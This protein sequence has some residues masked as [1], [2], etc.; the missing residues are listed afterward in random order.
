MDNAIALIEKTIE[1]HKTYLDRLKT[2]NDVANDV[3]ALRSLDKAQEAFVPG[4]LDA[5]AGLARLAELLDFIEHGL[6]A[7]FNREERALL[8]IFEK[9]GNKEM[10]DGFNS[11]LL[12]HGD[13]RNRI[14]QTRELVQK[15]TGGGLSGSQW[16]AT[17]NDLR[18]HISHTE[19]LLEAHADVEQELF[20]SLRNRLEFGK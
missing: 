19:K 1:E 5:K 10:M 20:A 2:M 7:H 18:A 11:L 9:H 14:V 13:L 15:L 4:R 8:D 12:E 17:A 3:E 16:Q 6:E